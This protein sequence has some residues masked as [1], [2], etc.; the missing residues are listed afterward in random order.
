[1][2]YDP[3]ANHIEIDIEEALNQ[4][5]VCFHSR[6]M[7]TILPVCPLPIL[8]LIELL[9]SPSCNE[10]NGIS[11]Y[12]SFPIVF[13]KKVDMVG[14]HHIVEHAQAEALLGFEKPLEI[15]TPVS[16]K[17][18]QKFFLVAPVGNV[19]N[20]TWDVMPIRPWHPWFLS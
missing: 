11:D 17:L 12:V 13:Y 2:A 1:V 19:P 18:Q 4:V 14:G 3:R 16:A 10:L 9:S 8:S 15:T 5:A 20:V 6:R 7:I